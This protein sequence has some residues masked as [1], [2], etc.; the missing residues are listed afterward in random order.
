MASTSN[1]HSC[2]KC[3]NTVHV[4]CGKTNGE[5]GFGGSVLCFLCFNEKQ[6]ELER[7][8]TNRCACRK[9]G[10]INLYNQELCIITEI[11]RNYV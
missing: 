7:C 9:A 10:Q 3:S 6:I 1:A 5:E 2:S 4:I 8:E 11:F